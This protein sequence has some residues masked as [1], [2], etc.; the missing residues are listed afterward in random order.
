MVERLIVIQV[1][2]GSSPSGCQALPRSVTVAH[3]SLKLVAVVRLH[4]GQKTEEGERRMF[5]LT[6]LIICLVI[7]GGVLTV[8][9]CD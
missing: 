8:V 6:A 7:L 9:S 4:A 3:E 5:S 1:V 2:E